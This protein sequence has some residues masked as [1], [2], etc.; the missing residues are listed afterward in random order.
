MH[1]LV[2]ISFL[3]FIFLNLIENLIHYNIGILRNKK[4]DNPLV[5][6]TTV[7]WFRIITIML[8]FACLQG[9]FVYLF[10]SKK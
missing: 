3:V 8:I 7:D 5:L 6:P 10:Y 4:L 9:I 1:N 2:L